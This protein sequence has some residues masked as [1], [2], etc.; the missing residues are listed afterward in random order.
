MTS[1]ALLKT[2]SLQSPCSEEWENWMRWDG[3]NDAQNA[4]LKLG[5]PSAEKSSLGSRKR[6]TS[7]CSD[8]EPAVSPDQQESKDPPFKRSHNIVERRY[9]T[10]INDKI[11]ALRDSVPSLRDAKDSRPRSIHSDSQPPQKLNKGTVL[12]TAVEY[13]RNLEKD[14]RRLELE[15]SHLRARLRAAEQETKSLTPPKGLSMSAPL[16]HLPMNRKPLLVYLP[17]P[18]CGP[19]LPRG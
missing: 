3:P 2:P 14:N 1:E 19:I 6:K 9:R 10:N 4:S 17:V 8:H 12:S 15:I 7:S 11:T 16:S 5:E 18:Q 13:I